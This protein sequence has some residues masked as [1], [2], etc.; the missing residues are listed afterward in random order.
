MLRGWPGLV[1]GDTALTRR[2]AAAA[3]R[4]PYRERLQHRHRVLGPRQRLLHTRRLLGGGGRAETRGGVVCGWGRPAGQAPASA[5]SPDCLALESR[6]ALSRSLAQ[7][8]PHA[9]VCVC[10][11]GV[12]HSPPATSLAARSTAAAFRSRTESRQPEARGC[13]WLEPRSR[14]SLPT[15]AE[16]PNLCF[17]LC[18][19][20]YSVLRLRT[21][22]S[23]LGMEGV[24]KAS[25]VKGSNLGRLGGGDGG[26]AIELHKHQVGEH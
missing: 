5:R 2:G 11:A 9:R 6:R 25:A 21:L 13:A 22:A 24:E 14:R 18:A 1:H 19:T 23:L 4:R 7:S 15:W 10:I 17:S 26:R 12:G 8:N 3:T 16:P 20:Y